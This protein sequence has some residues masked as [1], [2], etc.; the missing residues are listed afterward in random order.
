MLSILK[1]LPV[2]STTLSPIEYQYTVIKAFYDR[3]I[4]IHTNTIRIIFIWELTMTQHDL[5]GIILD[6]M[7]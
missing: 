4:F 2:L 5:S 6:G 7:I 3:F 1:L